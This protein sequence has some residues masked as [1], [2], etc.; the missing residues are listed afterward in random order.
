M[1]KYQIEIAVLSALILS[2][3]L[4]L[5][6]SESVRFFGKEH[7]GILIVAISVAC[8]VVCDWRTEKNLLDRIKKFF[9][10]CLVIGLLLEI[11]EAS[12]SDIQVEK[13]RNGNLVLQTNVASL[14]RAVLQLAHQYDLTTNA[15]AEANERTKEAEFKMAEA[16]S[17]I[18]LR[19]VFNE[20][21]EKRIRQLLPALQGMNVR[22]F[23]ATH[24][25]LNF[26][27]PDTKLL[28]E[29]LWLLFREA[30]CNVEEYSDLDIPSGGIQMLIRQNPTEGIKVALDQIFKEYGQQ[31]NIIVNPSGQYFSKETNIDLAVVVGSEPLFNPPVIPQKPDQ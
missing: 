20:E 30:G 17:K 16:G 12:K 27:D 24:N 10:I 28:S 4:L 9:G 23:R 19:K 18:P 25:W 3:I 2:F 26:D 1:H 11:V 31:P 7:P 5:S 15:L 14:N 21:S 8:E 6:F 22:V 29:Q 13:L